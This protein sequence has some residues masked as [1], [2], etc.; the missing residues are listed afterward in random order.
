MGRY[1]TPRPTKNITPRPTRNVTPRP[2]RSFTPRPTK[3]I[4]PRPTRNMTPRPTVWKTPKPTSP[5]KTPKPTNPPKTP[6]PTQ[7]YI[8]PTPKPT[9]G[10]GWG[11]AQPEPTVPM[12]GCAKNVDKNECK[13]NEACVWK[14]GY[15]P[16]AFSEDSDYQLVEEGEESI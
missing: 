1:V 4:T 6:R 13:S 11:V 16:L 8:A 3:N 12:T 2:T 9:V 15:P 7:T 14:S 10:G 5:P